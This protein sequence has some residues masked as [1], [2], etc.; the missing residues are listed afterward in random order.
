MEVIMFSPAQAQMD[1][2]LYIPA[3]LVKSQEINSVHEQL[4]TTY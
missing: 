2:V 4:L 1:H 3:E